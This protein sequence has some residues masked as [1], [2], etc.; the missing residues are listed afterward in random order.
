MQIFSVTITESRS[1]KIRLVAPNAEKAAEAARAVLRPGDRIGSCRLW[2]D[3][4]RGAGDNAL[5]H[6]LSRDYLLMGEDRSVVPTV[7]DWVDLAAAGDAK[8][9]D[10]LVLAGMRVI[11]S[12][13]MVGSPVS[14]PALAQWFQN[15]CWS[16][17]ELLA[18]LS[19]IDGASRTN[20]TFAGQPSRA[21]IVPMLAVKGAV[22]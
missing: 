16:G 17:S 21:V 3:R 10:R 18:V 4:D 13:L 9:N 8:A 22:Q 12:G 20:R 5:Q 2:G 19:L 15:T 14:I 7:R 6:L 1:R 11:D